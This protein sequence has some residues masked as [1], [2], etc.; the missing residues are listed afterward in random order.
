MPDFVKLVN[1]S[2]KPFDFHQSNARRIIDP[3]EDVIVPWNIAVTL[4]GHPNLTDVPP[5][6]ERTKMYEKIR[7]RHNYSAGLMTESEWENVRPRIAVYDL[8]RDTEVIML[9]DDP[10]G[11]HM[12]TA[13]D[14]TASGKKQDADALMRQIATLTRQVEKLIAGSQTGPQEAAQG[15]TASPTAVEDG[16]GTKQRDAPVGIDDA[17][18]IPTAD[19][20]PVTADE[21]QSVTVGEDAPPSSNTAPA[22]KIA[23][24]KVAAKK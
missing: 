4:F 11:N 12:H 21:P 5:A 15:N 23:A 16:P 3:G 24:K 7:S 20:T 2:T 1:E 17:F 22:K 6:N 8:E 14:L 18:N 19:D 10:E 9:I 13:P